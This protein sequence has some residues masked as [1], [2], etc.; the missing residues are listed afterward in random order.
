[1]NLNPHE[2]PSAV[3]EIA[4]VLGGNLALVAKNY[5]PFYDALVKAN[6][7]AKPVLAVILGTI[8]VENPTFNIGHEKGGPTYFKE[9]YDITS[10][11]PNRRKVA[12]NLGNDKPGDGIK[13]HGRGLIQI[14][15][16]FNYAKYGKKIGV[17][18]VANPDAAL[19]PANA[20][21]IFVEYYKDHGIDVW[22]NKW[23]TAT[24]PADKE[25]ALQKCRRLVNGGLTHYDRFKA[26]TLAFLALQA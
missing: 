9:M 19:E 15:G 22:A 25:A 16:K 18:L 21:R 3:G 14:T 24:M 2:N 5:P 26:K 4:K 17:D 1:M 10:S 11:K 8:A 12:K 6:C 20:F 13:Y 23:H 7:T